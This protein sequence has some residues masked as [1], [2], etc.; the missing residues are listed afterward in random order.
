MLAVA[1]NYYTQIFDILVDINKSIQT[2]CLSYYFFQPR[3]VMELIYL[4]SPKNINIYIHNFQINWGDENNFDPVLSI[5][6]RQCVVSDDVF[7][8]KTEKNSKF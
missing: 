2:V 6:T 3:N 4:F 8:D 5:F 1:I 7:E